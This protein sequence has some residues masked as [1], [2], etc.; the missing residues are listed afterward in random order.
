MREEMKTA[1]ALIRSYK[2]GGIEPGTEISQEQD[3]LIRLLA[4][5]LEVEVDGLR[6]GAIVSR[7]ARA[8]TRWNQETM[9]A[10]C[11][12]YDRRQVGGDEAAEVVRSAFLS[13]CPSVWYCGV[14]EGL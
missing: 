12:F 10:V 7:V 9:A 6:I 1:Y 5:D 4:T 2:T 8:D 3:R 14:L 13:R 11:E